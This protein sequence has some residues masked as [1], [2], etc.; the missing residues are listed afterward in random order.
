VESSSSNFLLALATS[1]FRVLPCSAD[2]KREVLENY[3]DR[4]L[5]ISLHTVGNI[6]ALLSVFSSGTQR[7]PRLSTVLEGDCVT[8]KLGFLIA[9]VSMRATT[10]K[11]TVSSPATVTPGYSQSSRVVARPC[12]A[13]P[14]VSVRA[15][16]DFL[17][18]EKITG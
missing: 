18:D 13:L 10:G 6:L 11:R 14:V 7:P 2:C 5:C 16:S 4:C 12:P 1:A 17:V 3:E 9:N 8:A 15:M